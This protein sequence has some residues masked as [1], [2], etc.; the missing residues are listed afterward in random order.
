[1]KLKIKVRIINNG[2][3]VPKIYKKGEWIDLSVSEPVYFDA[4]QAGILKKFGEKSYRNV[5]FSTAMVPL[6]IAMKLPD[7]FEAI[8]APRSSTFKNFGIMQTNSF[9]VIDNSY[10]GNNDEWKIPVVAFKNTKLDCG[11]RICQFRIQLSQKATLWQKIKWFF[12]SGIEIVHVAYLDNK[13]R[14]GFGT[15]GVK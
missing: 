14:G 7:G 11:D 12:S 1:M 6:G 15:T 9:G 8:L 3:I 2:M 4:P 13:D 10:S 5:T